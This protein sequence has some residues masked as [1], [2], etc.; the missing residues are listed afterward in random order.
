MF[1]KWAEVQPL[2][3]QDAASVAAALTKI[4]CRW[5]PPSVIRMDN[6]TEFRNAVVAALLEQFGVVVKTGAVRHPQSQGGVERLNRTIIGLLRKALEETSDWTS[7][8][9]LVLFYYNRRRHATTGISPRLAITGWEGRDL[10]I[11]HDPTAYSASE[12]VDRLAGRAA[13]IR[14]LVE[15]LLS[16]NDSVSGGPTESP[17]RVDD[18]VMLRRPERSQKLMTPYESGWTVLKIV[19]PSTLVIQHADGREKVVNVDI[20]KPGHAQ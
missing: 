3:R 18:P 10:V 19:S 13:R 16:S 9:E 1:T 2:R 6:G 14:D 11:D 12:W 20:V 7:E 17:Y 15:S 5:G 8:L 4:C